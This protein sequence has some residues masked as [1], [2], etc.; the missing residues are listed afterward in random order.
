M[1]KKI[2]EGVA[3]LNFPRLKTAATIQ[4]LLI[5]SYVVAAVFN[6]GK[7]N[8]SFAT[9]PLLNKKRWLRAIAFL[10]AD[11]SIRLFYEFFCNF[12][13]ADYDVKTVGR[14]GNA[15]TLKVVVYGSCILF[16]FD[17][18]NCCNQTACAVEAINMAVFKH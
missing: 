4:S 6:R 12:V 15:Y 3:E 8:P 2:P 7:L 13:A 14:L 5:I 16:N 1:Y 11:M 10:F 9:P 18:F 17:A